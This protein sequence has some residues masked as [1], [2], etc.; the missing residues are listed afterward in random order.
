MG[1]NSSI[2]QITRQKAWNDSVGRFISRI[3]R[4]FFILDVEV[5]SNVNLSSG[6]L[7]N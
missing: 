5:V 2:N 6:E 4:N 1:G 7:N 3:V